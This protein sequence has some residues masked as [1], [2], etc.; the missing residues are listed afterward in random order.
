MRWI[1]LSTVSQIFNLKLSFLLLSATVCSFK[2]E[3]VQV[4][5]SRT[6]T[7]LVLIRFV[8]VMMWRS[9]SPA[10]VRR[11]RTGEAPGRSWLG[12]AAV[13]CAAARRW[14]RTSPTACSRSTAAW[15]TTAS[16]SS[17]SRTPEKGRA[18]VLYIQ[19]KASHSEDK[20]Y[21]LHFRGSRWTDW[22]AELFTDWL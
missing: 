19:D 17:T 13:S 6:Q 14:S 22:A 8:S 20:H 16:P 7:L 12:T 9:S 3:A 18:L 11:R 15:C 5:T 1:R 2:L 21:F 4:W 10:V